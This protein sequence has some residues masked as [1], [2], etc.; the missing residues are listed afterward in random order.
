MFK[1]LISLGDKSANSTEAEGFQSSILNF[2]FCNVIIGTKGSSPL[3]RE[4]ILNG[5]NIKEYHE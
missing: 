4:Q 2:V 1:A 5:F 3:V